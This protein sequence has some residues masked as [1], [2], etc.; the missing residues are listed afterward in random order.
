MVIDI[1]MLD[2]I[3]SSYKYTEIIKSQGDSML[4]LIQEHSLIFVDTL[5]KNI[6]S[7]NIYV[8]NG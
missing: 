3:N 1:Y 7:K 5:Y 4:P 8:I 2:Y 6:N